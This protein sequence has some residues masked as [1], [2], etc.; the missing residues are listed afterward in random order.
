MKHSTRVAQREVGGRRS[1]KVAEEP[2]QSEYHHALRVRQRFALRGGEV[3]RADGV[4]LTVSDEIAHTR[5]PR[6]VRRVRRTL[7][8]GG[9]VVPGGGVA[10]LVAAASLTSPGRFTG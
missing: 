1:L 4:K 9:R 10:E 7:M 6:L 5:R 3:R 8:N 2:P